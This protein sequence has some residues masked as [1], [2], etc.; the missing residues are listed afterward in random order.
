MPKLLTNKQR[1]LN[2]TEALVAEIL[3]LPDEVILEEA[4]EDGF[5]TAAFSQQMRE[6]LRQMIKERRQTWFPGDSLQ[7]MTI[8]RHTLEMGEISGFGGG[9]EKCCQ[10]MLEAGVKW[11]NAHANADL[12]G[13]TYA[14]VYGVMMADSDDAK[15]LSKCISDASGPDGCTGAMHQAV[16]S[17][18]FYIA[19][20]GWH[21]Y[22]WHKYAVERTKQET[23]AA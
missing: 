18:L 6:D 13:H 2:L 11:L 15:D 1:L 19:K 8:F 16:L 23:A 4:R 12:K 21:K 5:D 7:N 22:A 9:Y 10:D 20:H 14:N 3:A 17:N